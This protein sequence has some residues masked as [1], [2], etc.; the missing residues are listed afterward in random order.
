MLTTITQ[1]GD[2]TSG[3]GALG[4]DGKAF[5]IQLITFILAYLVLRRYAF[6]PIIK[7]LNERRE[8]IENGVKL[9]DQLKQEEAKLEAKVEKTLQETRQKADG[10]IADAQDNGRQIV[11]EAEDK[12]REK[13]AGVVA[14]AESRIA[15][16]TARA[17]QSLE[18]ELVG[19]VSDA[20]E[21]IVEEKIDP[22]KDAAL[23]DRALKEKQAA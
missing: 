2:S 9:G 3:I 19:L 23:I 21:A 15:Q 22:K 13:A 11:K 1:F 20:T 4:F 16:D 17:R 6:G 5:V 14:E 7:V 18:K 12:A 8:T 10:I